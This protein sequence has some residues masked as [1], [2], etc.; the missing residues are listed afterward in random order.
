MGSIC[1]FRMPASAQWRINLLPRRKLPAVR[2]CGCDSFE[3]MRIEKAIPQFGTDMDE[4]NIPLEAGLDER[5]IS[6]KKGC[7]I[8]QEVISRIRT[9]GHVAK[10]LRALEL[11]SELKNLPIK[12]DKLFQDEKEVGYIT[13]A[14]RS[15][16]QPRVIA[17]GYVRKEANRI[18]TELRLRNAG[19]D[20]L[21]LVAGLPFRA[22][23]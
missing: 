18:G 12:G 13:S 16:L 22:L 21:A 6:F 14:T 11:S 1:L 9:Y 3:I 4:T 17:L 10:A 2:A 23:E 5:A 8:G 19:G 20:S 15:L 7:Y